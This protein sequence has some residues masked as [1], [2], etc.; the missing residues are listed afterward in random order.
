VLE[1]SSIKDGNEQLKKVRCKCIKELNI[2]G[3]AAAG[4]Q[5]VVG[6]RD[7]EKT[8]P[9]YGRLW[10]QWNQTSKKWDITGLDL[11]AGIKAKF[12]KPCTVL[13]RGCNAADG[14]AGRALLKGIANATGCTAKGW[15]VVTTEATP[16]QGLPGSG[17]L[18]IK[19]GPDLSVEPD[20]Q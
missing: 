13:V 18:G 15:V 7:P 16:Y 2:L 5:N 11:F 20:P 19:A 17:F 1:V 9:G 6:T 3:H 14:A 10:A 4:M 12:C 8:K